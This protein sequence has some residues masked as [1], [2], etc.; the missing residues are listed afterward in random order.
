MTA[1]SL[2]AKMTL[3][4]VT[5]TV[6]VLFVAAFALVSLFTHE[7][8]GG[9]DRLLAQEVEMVEEALVFDKN[10]KIDPFFLTPKH[11][12]GVTDRAIFQIRSPNGKVLVSAPELEGVVLPM[13]VR[14][15]HRGESLSMD[16]AINS[17]KYRLNSRMHPKEHHTG[18]EDV[19]VQVIRPL[20]YYQQ[21]EGNLSKLI[22]QLL[23]FPI[24]LVGLG[25]WVVVTLTLRPINQIV[26]TVQKM[27]AQDLGARLP[28]V[29]NDELGRLATTFNLLFERLQKS[30]G[31]L[32]RFTADASHELRTPLTAIRTQ[33]EVLLSHKRQPKEYQDT[34]GS[35]LEEI[36]RLEQLTDTL[37][38]L[39]R[40]DANTVQ[41][42]WSLV[43]VSQLVAEWVERLS[44]VAEDKQ[45]VLNLRV[46][47]EIHITADPFIL[48]RIITNLLSNAISYTPSGGIITVVLKRL[49]ATIE[50][51]ISDTGPGIP[52]AARE[53]VF[54]RFVRL[55]STRHQSSGSG[56]GLSIVK[57]AVDIHQGAVRIESVIPHGSQFVV[58]LPLQAHS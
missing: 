47:P 50:L 20:K 7:M 24:L 32:K 8:R 48:E 41:P 12:T 55:S 5:G 39:A 52:E 6:L 1:W 46:E 37:L 35:I 57:W 19:L 45:L 49:S 38:Q 4:S 29:R 10:G 23:P 18:P 34:I 36:S 11:Q 31:S 21:Q 42:Q 30:F 27:N 14:L 2:R 54:E 16:V 17:E 33:S 26:D 13:P 15:P 28:V 51:S 9:L 43:C 40:T 53:Q 58:S 25:S 22:W 3:L 44:V 56:L